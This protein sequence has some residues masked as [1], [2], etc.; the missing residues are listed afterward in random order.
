MFDPRPEMRTA[1]L[2]FFS[3][4]IP[5]KVGTHFPAWRQEWSSGNQP[6]CVAL[7]AA[8][9]LQQ[10]ALP[11]TVQPFPPAWIW[12]MRVAASPSTVRAYV[13]FAPSPSRPTSPT[14]TPLLHGLAILPDPTLPLRSQERRAT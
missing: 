9:A 1:T 3:I 14:P 6:L 10:S 2:A 8:R 12:P 13:T 11:R 5:V 7:H 4:I